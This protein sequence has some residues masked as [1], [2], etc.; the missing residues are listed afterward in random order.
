MVSP[1]AW[2]MNHSY[3]LTLKPLHWIFL[4]L[5]VCMCICRS[6]TPVYPLMETTAAAAWSWLT[7]SAKRPSSSTEIKLLASRDRKKERNCWILLF[8]SPCC[9]CLF[10][11]C[12]KYS[13]TLTL[14]CI[15][16]TQRATRK[17]IDVNIHYLLWEC[18][19]HIF[20]MYIFYKRL[21][22]DK[23]VFIVFIKYRVYVVLLSLQ[24]LDGECTVDAATWNLL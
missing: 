8:Y 22:C 7:L 10:Y 12:G 6:K 3:C 4:C 20:L 16:Q 11:I 17:K 19:S 5:C 23:K 9:C 15:W 18:T 24:W 2:I 21:N 14:Y 13:E 1:E